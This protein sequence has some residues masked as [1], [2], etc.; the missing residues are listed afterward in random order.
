MSIRHINKIASKP[1]LK[2]I[3]YILNAPESHVHLI[4]FHSKK[5]A[6]EWGGI[7]LGDE[8]ENKFTGCA[9]SVFILIQNDCLEFKNTHQYYETL[10]AEL[11]VTDFGI[12]LLEKAK[13]LEII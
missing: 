11:H 10:H 4:W 2:I 12:K 13:E 9:R 8:M 7:R 5:Y 1:Q 3:D 6:K